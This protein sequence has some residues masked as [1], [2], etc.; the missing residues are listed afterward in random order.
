M[1]DEPIVDA[2]FHIWRLAATPWLAGPPVPRIFGAYE[3]LRR[4]YLI[5]E[6]LAAARPCGVVKSVFVQVNVAPAARSRKSPLRKEPRTRTASRTRSRPS[7]ISRRR[8]SAR[9][10][11]ARWRRGACGRSASS[12][13]GIA[14]R[15]TA[16][17]PGPT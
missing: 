10:S 6:Y 2:H 12:S 17:P 4:D 16:S 1:A 5:E 13:T 3:P 7:P 11:T 8:T 14:T 9:R 15:N